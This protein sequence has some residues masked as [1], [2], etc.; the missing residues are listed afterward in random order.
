[1]KT[2]TLVSKDL[3]VG[4]YREVHRVCGSNFIRQEMSLIYC[5]F[6]DRVGKL[7]NPLAS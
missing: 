2:H 7:D 1:M 4:E 6:Y 3:R 5:I